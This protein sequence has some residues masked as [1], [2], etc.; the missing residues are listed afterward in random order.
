MPGQEARRYG[1]QE[2][3]FNHRASDKMVS[4]KTPLT[5]LMGRTSLARP[6][7]RK[8]NQEPAQAGGDRGKNPGPEREEQENSRH[9]Y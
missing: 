7:D 4:R 5:P 1:Q 9:L 2:K 3:A 8:P 6:G